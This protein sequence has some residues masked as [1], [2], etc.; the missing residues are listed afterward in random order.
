M[1]AAHSTGA[2]TQFCSAITRGV[3]ASL[4]TKMDEDFEF[5][6]HCLK[7]HF[8]RT[9]SQRSLTFVTI[10][11]T[12]KVFNETGGRSEVLPDKIRQFFRTGTFIYF[13]VFY[14]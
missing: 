11:I 2:P 5:R 3:Q 10:I 12:S 1:Q 14:L 6:I 8:N 9:E 7:Q 13:I 4:K